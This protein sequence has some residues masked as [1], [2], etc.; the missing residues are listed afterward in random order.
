MREEYRVM[1]QRGY[2]E[3]ENKWLNGGS[4]Y[5]DKRY[6]DTLEEAIKCRDIILEKEKVDNSLTVVNGIGIEIERDEKALKD[7][8]LKRIKIEKRKVTEWES[9][10]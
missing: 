5:A 1:F 3:R 7:I 6:F 10:E 8:E 9:A 4:I 2:E